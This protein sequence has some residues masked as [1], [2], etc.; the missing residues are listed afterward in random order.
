[1][2]PKKTRNAKN[3][4]KRKAVTFPGSEDEDSDNEEKCQKFC[5]YYDKCGQIIDKC[6]TLKALIKLA[7]QKRSEH[8][9]KE[10]ESIKQEINVI[11]ERKHWKKNKVK[12]TEELRVF[13]TISVSNPNQESI[14]SSSNEEDE[15]LK[16][17][18]R[19]AKY[20]KYY[21]TKNWNNTQKNFLI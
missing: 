19:Q 4:K 6:T 14:N 17:W 8:F 21:S 5:K 1:M 11:A 3:C 16:N 7:K 12:R 2:F 9:K 20:E 13:E 15:N 10:K 18:L